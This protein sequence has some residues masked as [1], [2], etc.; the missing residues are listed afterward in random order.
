MSRTRLAALTALLL[1]VLS[2]AVFFTRRATG[3]AE[4]GGPSGTSSWEVTVTVRGVVDTAKHT[5]VVV[6]TPPEFRRQHVYEESWKCD[7]LMRH[8]GRGSAAKEGRDRETTWKRRPMAGDKDR[9]PFTLTYS[10]LCT[11]GMHKPTAAMTDR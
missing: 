2:T 6:S 10:F 5:P 7:E 1:M 8:E 9:K 11:L 4:V 3:G